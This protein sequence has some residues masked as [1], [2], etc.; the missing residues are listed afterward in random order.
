MSAGECHHSSEL[1][2]A[3]KKRYLNRRSREVACG[4][5]GSQRSRGYFNDL[6]SPEVSLVEQTLKVVLSED[7]DSRDSS[8]PVAALPYRWRVSGACRL[9]HLATPQPATTRDL[10]Q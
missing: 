4:G 2:T 7:A 6:D 8:S 3:A 10:G 1:G 5:E 9:E